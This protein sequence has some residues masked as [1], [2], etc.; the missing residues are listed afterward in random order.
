[1]ENSGLHKRELLKHHEP[2]PMLVFEGSLSI[3]IA[4]KWSVKDT[5]TWLFMVLLATFASVETLSILDPCQMT[6][7][8]GWT[9]GN[10]GSPFSI[11]PQAIWIMAWG[12][13]E[14]EVITETACIKSLCFISTTPVHFIHS[15]IKVSRYYFVF[16]SLIFVFHIIL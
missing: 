6:Y 10:L 11:D 14:N 2:F 3:E 7:H 15:T 8:S 1:M 9:Q 16:I 4:L 5:F 13:M 12:S